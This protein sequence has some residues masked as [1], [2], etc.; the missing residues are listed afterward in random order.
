MARPI[1]TFTPE[2]AA[3]LIRTFWLKSRGWE[4]IDFEK[5]LRIDPALTGDARREQLTEI[6]NAAKQVIDVLMNAKDKDAVPA[7]LRA[8]IDTYLS[9]TGWKRI[10]AARRQKKSTH[11]NRDLLTKISKESSWDFS[12]LA[13]AAGLTKKDYL[14]QLAHWMLNQNAGQKAA[15]AFAASLP[16]KRDLLTK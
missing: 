5:N 11:S 1:K 14:S 6:S 15:A 13:E 16:V 7:A 9:E 10:Q 2:E 4:W 8:W 3:T 12:H